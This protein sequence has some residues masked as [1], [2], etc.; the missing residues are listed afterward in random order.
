MRLRKYHGVLLVVV[1]LLMAGGQSVI[2]LRKADSAPLANESKAE[3]RKSWPFLGIVGCIVT[4]MGIGILRL[5]S[6][7]LP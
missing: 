1:G 5:P 6:E 7:S 4:L 2:S 3:T